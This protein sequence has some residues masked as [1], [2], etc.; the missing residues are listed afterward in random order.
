MM[1]M[2]YSHRFVISVELINDRLTLSCRYTNVV[3]IAHEAV[4]HASKKKLTQV[5]GNSIGFWPAILLVIINFATYTFGTT[6]SQCCVEI[7]ETF[8]K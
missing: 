6:F 3:V 4:I 1:I 7:T 5:R 2:C 8:E